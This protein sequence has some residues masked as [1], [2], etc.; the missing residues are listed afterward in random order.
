MVV[1][2]AAVCTRNGRA[3]VSRQFIEMSRMRIEGLLAAFPKLISSDS[4]AQHTFVETESVRYVY[5]P[6]ESLYILLITNKQSNI[7][8]DL[9]TL[10]LLSKVVADV[11]GGVTAEKVGDAAF[12]VIFAFDEAIAVGGYKENVTIRQIETNLEM[13][14]HEEKLALMIKR[15]REQQ[16][17]KDMQAKAA[18]IRERQ[19]NMQRQGGGGGGGG[20]GMASD[21]FGTT[22]SM[23]AGAPMPSHGDG[24]SSMSSAGAYSMSEAKP[25]A[26]EPPRAA[27]KGMKLGGKSSM[28]GLLSQL[29]AEDNLNVAMLAPQGTQEAE[30]LQE[31]AGQREQEAAAYPLSLV[32]EEKVTVA[33]SREGNVEAMDVKGSLA[34]TANVSEASRCAVAVRLDGAPSE[35]TFQTHPK[36]NKAVFEG[37]KVLTGKDPARGFPAGRSVG[38]LRWSMSTTSEDLVPVSINCWPEDDGNG[39]MTVSVEYQRHRAMPLH[40]VSFVLPVGTE[41]SPDIL[42]CSSGDCRFDRANMALIWQFNM[43]DDSNAT[44]TLEFTVDGDDADAFFPVRVAFRSEEPYCPISIAETKSMAD[45]NVLHY[46]FSKTLLADG[47]TIQ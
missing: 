25:A 29:A 13:E 23:L 15:D 39:Q 26:R 42:E 35:M 10:R 22:P 27:A 37:S 46:D 24:S 5:Q 14:S 40:N 4:Q 28:G 11:A 16:A 45:N 32:V 2:S 20:G 18:E 47:Y 34:L 33:L 30:A 38:V 1:L 36:I 41:N 19:R 31:L 21:G 7:V 44:G 3:L 6:V 9:E 17:K 8:E 12:E 43:I